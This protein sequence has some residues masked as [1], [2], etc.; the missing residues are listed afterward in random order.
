MGFAPRLRL[1]TPLP[2][3]GRI[4]K[5]GLARAGEGTMGYEPMVGVLQDPAPANQALTRLSPDS[6]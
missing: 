4:E 2:A 6:V 3:I 1:G 5:S